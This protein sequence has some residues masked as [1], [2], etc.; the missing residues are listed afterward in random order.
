MSEPLPQ[1][2]KKP[3]IVLP[4][5]SMAKKDI[6][7]LNENGFVVVE[8]KDPNLVRFL[9]PPPLNYSEQ[10]KAA[11][12]LC[13]VLFSSQQWNA[14]HNRETLTS[15]FVQILIQGTPLSDVPPEK[16]AV[17]PKTKPV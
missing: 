15:K 6:E 13:R 7:K 16:V 14:T 1:F 5:K 10:E 11:I 12:R 4:P 9:E 8:C 3:V 2:T 17:V